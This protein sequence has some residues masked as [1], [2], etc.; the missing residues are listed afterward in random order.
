MAHYP[1]NV[2]LSGRRCVVIG[3]GTVAGRKAES[4]LDAGAAV[5]VVAPE[6]APPLAEMAQQGL[7]EHVRAPYESGH[8]DDAFLA[9]AATDDREVNRAV[10]RDAESRGILVN[11][12]DDPELCV[13]YVPAVVR[14]GDFIISVSTSGKAPALA[15]LVREQLESQYGPEYGE[16]AELMGELRDEIKARH[17][18]S[19][20]RKRAYARI[21]DS[22]ALRLLAQGKRDE[23]RQ[24]ALQCI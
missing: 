17:P 6:L 7:I 8:L 20:G 24:R 5:T 23:A 3:G 13:F 16:L 22:D 9:I 14:R 10:Y 11:V 12:V 19:A 18:D 2:D 15:K 21:L 4:L 1:I